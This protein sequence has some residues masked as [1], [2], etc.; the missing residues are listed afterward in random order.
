MLGP[1]LLEALRLRG[2]EKA[3]IEPMPLAA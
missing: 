2:I 3:L 1:E